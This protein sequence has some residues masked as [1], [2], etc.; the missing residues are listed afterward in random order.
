MKS[1]ATSL[2]GMLVIWHDIALGHATEVREWYAREHHFERLAVPGFLEASR[3]DRLQGIGGNVLGLY[4]V[5]APAVLQ[6][7]AYRACLAAPTPWT[8]EVMPHFR[9]MSRTVCRIA[10][11]AGR[12]EGSYLAALAP[13]ADSVASTGA[14]QAAAFDTLCAALLL[15]PGM[16]RVRCLAAAIDGSEAA[17]TS[18]EAALRGRPDA[19]VAWAVLIDTDSAEAAQAAL[20]AAC[21][22]TGTADPAQCA[23]YRL[24]FAAR[25]PS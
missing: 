16:L 4:R 10:A 19:G 20:D 13:A 11:Q 18:S 3:Y 8:Q 1:A 21:A 17:P 7:A 2:G 5:D 25:N 23:V 15:R 24:A 14:F 9:A 12:A 22:H 6:S